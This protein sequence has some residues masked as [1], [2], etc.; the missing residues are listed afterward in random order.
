MQDPEALGRIADEALANL[1]GGDTPSDDRRPP[2]PPQRY[3]VPSPGTLYPSPH[4][5]HPMVIMPIYNAPPYPPV[6]PYARRPSFGQEGYP[7]PYGG[8][9]MVYAPQMYRE[10]PQKQVDQEERVDVKRRSIST[11]RGSVPGRKQSKQEQRVVSTM[12]LEER[13]AE[14]EEDE[15]E[16]EEKRRESV[17]KPF[18]RPVVQHVAQQVVQPVGLEHSRGLVYGVPPPSQNTAIESL[19]KKRAKPR[20]MTRD[21]ISIAVKPNGPR[22]EGS[23]KESNLSRRKSDGPHAQMNGAEKPKAPVA[24][25]DHDVEKATLASTLQRGQGSCDEPDV[26]ETLNVPHRETIGSEQSA[27]PAEGTPVSETPAYEDIRDASKLTTS[28][29]PAPP[30]PPLVEQEE[31]QEEE[32]GEEESTRPKS[33]DESY[34]DITG[35]ST[36]VPAESDADGE[37]D[38][39]LAEQ[40][41]HIT[42]KNILKNRKKGTGMGKKK[43][44][45]STT[46]KRKAVDGIDT[47]KKK[48]KNR[49]EG[50]SDPLTYDL[51]HS[52]TMGRKR[53]RIDY[54]AMSRG[55]PSKS[56]DNDSLISPSLSATPS[57]PDETHPTRPS[58]PT[59]LYCICRQPLTDANDSQFFI[60]CD[61]CDEWFHGDCVGISEEDAKGI[62]KWVCPVCQKDRGLQTVWKERCK[63]CCNY[64]ETD[65]AR[66]GYCSDTCGMSTARALL[67]SLHVVLKPLPKRNP[68]NDEITRTA[69]LTADQVDQSH[70]LHLRTRRRTLISLLRRLETRRTRIRDAIIKCLE[71]NTDAGVSDPSGRICGFDSRIVT[72]WV[73]DHGISTTIDNDDPMETPTEAS[74]CKITGKCPHH[75]HWERIKYAEVE[76]EVRQVLAAVEDAAKER[77]MVLASLRR[78]RQIC[79]RPA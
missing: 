46:R 29:P 73:V 70:L 7:I 12:D 53:K 47:G 75:E 41:V 11:R 51:Y 15:E 57:E 50:I 36:P 28:P 66:H 48:V 56:D 26:S 21:K 76:L 61:G 71:L 13:D 39:N 3:Y 24:T 77:N 35:T 44:G 63:A 74:L 14:G 65:S 62:A 52:L 22:E 18:V 25:H 45:V 55:Q 72:V 37:A 31:E 59:K 49:K 68:H 20:D 58:D 78:R 5:P 54:A 27:R 69:I 34:I 33:D 40:L 4:P 10:R 60:G 8:Y 23:R 38:M 30:P 2:F 19:T 67:E 43:G 17:V 1:T 9:P 64:I 6:Y 16:Q 32:L 79:G 42:D